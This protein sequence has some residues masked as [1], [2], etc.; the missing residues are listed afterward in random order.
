MCGIIGVISRPPTRPVPSESEIV[1]LLDRA[2][3]AIDDV[4]AVT[5]LLVAVDALLKGLPGLMALV[6]RPQLVTAITARL[7]QLDAFVTAVDRRLETDDLGAD[8][9][10]RRGAE[11][12]AL[13]DALWAIRNDR[14]RTAREVS[15][16]AGR[17][18]GQGPL[19][20]YLAIQQAFSALD[21]LE[22]RGRDSA[23][24]H[25]FVH[26]HGLD[27]SDPALHA[28]IRER[29]QDPTFQS[30]SVRA[31]GNVLSFV[32]KAAAEIGE[33]GDNTRVMRAAVASDQLLRRAVAASSARTSVLGHTRWASVGI[34]SEPNAHP[35]NS[36]ELESTGG[37]PYLVAA[38]NGDVD[39]HA[40]L[41]VEHQLRIHQQITTDAKV[42]PALVSRHL[43]AGHDDVE[44]FRRTV[45]AFHG[46]VAIAA[47]SSSHPDSLLLAL[48]G[49]GQG[50]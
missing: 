28:A 37:A 39:N 26:G 4:C 13:R 34:I 10:E 42:I 19:A 24:I 18:A 21:R 46:S 31:V 1:E 23:G 15:N 17:D 11:A 16:L 40:D 25:L 2:V 45:A 30:G 12:I 35:I 20:A 41:R 27:L 29:A 6:D 44:S 48:S 5:D 3:T 22:V 33:L 7:D 50:L 32:Y 9:L 8:E 49:S 47:M 36:D 43:A 38:L 14:L